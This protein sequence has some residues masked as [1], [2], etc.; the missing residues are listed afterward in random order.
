MLKGPSL[1]YIAMEAMGRQYIRAKELDI[2]RYM[3]VDHGLKPKPLKRQLTKPNMPYPEES[4]ETS[5]NY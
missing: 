3:N 2:T 5:T 4:T 1:S